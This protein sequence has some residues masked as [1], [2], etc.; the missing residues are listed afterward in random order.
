[1]WKEHAQHE[2]EGHDD[3]G[4]YDCFLQ[5]LVDTLGQLCSEIES[6]YGLHALTDA[7]NHHDG[8]ERNAVH[9]AVGGNRH[10]ATM[11]GQS[12]V[13]EDDNETGTQ[14]HGKR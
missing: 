11:L 13:D 14:L 6:S 7:Q 10:I 2:I 1:M 4:E 8:K 5:H 9:N 12:L 3:G